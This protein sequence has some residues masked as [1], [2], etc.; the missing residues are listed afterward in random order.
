LQHQND[1]YSQLAQLC[2]QPPGFEFPRQFLPSCFHFTEPYSNPASREHTFCPFDRLTGQP[3]IYA[4][5][6]TVQ[7]R[8][9]E[10]FQVTTQVA[11]K[12]MMDVSINIFLRPAQIFIF[13]FMSLRTVQILKILA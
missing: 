3:L 9:L 13:C 11:S 7:N 4:S 5:L 1:A 8:L 6:G 10:T 12:G 2:Q